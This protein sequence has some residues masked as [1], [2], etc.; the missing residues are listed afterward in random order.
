[1]PDIIVGWDTLAV[2]WAST[3]AISE[4][5]DKFWDLDGVAAQ[6]RT[7]A[8]GIVLGAAGGIFG[9]GMFADPAVCGEAAMPAVLCGA[10]VGLVAA[11]L[12]NFA[13]LLPVVK[14]VLEKVKI[15]PKE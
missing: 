11:I 7:W 2:I 6:I 8:I 1:M 4:F 15:R 9:L 14:W 13:F 12:A 10:I 3:I 5:V